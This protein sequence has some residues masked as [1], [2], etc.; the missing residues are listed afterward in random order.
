MLFN[1]RNGKIED[2]FFLYLFK[3]IYSKHR[4]NKN[5]FFIVFGKSYWISL[6]TFVLVIQ[7]KN[8]K[9]IKNQFNGKASQVSFLSFEFFSKK[10]KLFFLFLKRFIYVHNFVCFY[11]AFIHTAF[12]LNYR[13]KY[14]LIFKYIYLGKFL[15]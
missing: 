3:K 2:S 8:H 1:T 7:S 5:F 9:S 6:K 12:R 4:E 13:N 10:N 14:Y 15:R 11:I